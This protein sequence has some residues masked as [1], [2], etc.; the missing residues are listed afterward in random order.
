MPPPVPTVRPP[1]ERTALAAYRPGLI[2]HPT[3]IAVLLLGDGERGVGEMLAALGCDG[4]HLSQHLIPLRLAG[5]VEP[6][7]DGKR[8]FYSL[9]D[10]GRTIVRAV[11]ALTD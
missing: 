4:P 11:E 3:R 9:A 7:R 6:R 5:L 1:A 10:A 2:A 8:V